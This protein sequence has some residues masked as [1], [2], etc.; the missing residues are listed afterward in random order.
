MSITFGAWGL[1]NVIC[2]GFPLSHLLLLRIVKQLEL[3]I[4]F[5]QYQNVEIPMLMDE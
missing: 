3:I 4:D 1:Y 2:E 5:S